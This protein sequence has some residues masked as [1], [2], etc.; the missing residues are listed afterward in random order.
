LG[1]T[2]GGLGLTNSGGASFQLAFVDTPEINAIIRAVRKRERATLLTAPR[3]TVHNT[4][5]AHVSVLNEVAYISDFNTSTATG[6]AVADPV[7]SIIRDGI[8]LDVR[9]TVSA[10]R[11]YITLELRPT[12]AIL[13]RQWSPRD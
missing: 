8:V 3:V 7:V 9:P 13:L 10:D 4:Q 2:R 6:I 12:L 5:R 11:R 1:G